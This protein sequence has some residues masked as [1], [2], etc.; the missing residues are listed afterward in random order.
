M[1]ILV[2]SASGRAY[3]P[4]IEYT[5]AAESSALSGA[6]PWL[7][8]PHA[9]FNG[10][11]KLIISSV[12]PVSSG[13]SKRD[14]EVLMRDF[15][16]YNYRRKLCDIKTCRKGQLEDEQLAGVGGPVALE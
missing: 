16:A 4:R 3:K 1:Q 6:L 15:L 14:K 5:N 8:T 12:S 2:L 9:R 11:Y 10:R 13:L 7:E